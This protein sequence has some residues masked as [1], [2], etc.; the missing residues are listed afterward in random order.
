MV[1]LLVVMLSG[2]DISYSQNWLWAKSAAGDNKDKSYSVATDGSGNV[3]VT[4]DYPSSS[5]TFGAYTL[6]NLGTGNGFLVKY[7]ASGNVLWA[8]NIGGPGDALG[9]G[10][11]IDGSG[12]I[13][14][15]GCF[16]QPTITVGTFTL[17]NTNTFGY[18]DI[19]LAKY[20]PSG[21]VLWA[22]S[23][24]GAT[25]EQA[26]AV[27]VDALG[28]AYITGEFGDFMSTATITFG[29]I[30]LTASNSG[31]H[32][33]FLAKY[34]P[35]GNVLWA[36]NAGGG[37]WDQAT[38]VAADVSGNAYI[39]GYFSS[40]TIPFGAFPLTNAGSGQNVFLVKYYPTGTVL[41]A[42]SAGGIAYDGGS[43][44]AD[45]PAGNVYLTGGFSSPT[46]TFG[47][48][49]LT[50]AGS[51]DVFLTKYDPSGAVLWAQNAG[52]N[53]DDGGGG[54]AV[55]GTASVYLTGGFTS[56][57]ILKR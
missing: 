38:S 11:A 8:Q 47:A 25:G 21:T 15:S 46:I 2:V 28:N 20:D 26:T 30:T 41:W 16:G 17:T 42:Q 39:T 49:T 27:A 32:D 45:D 55:N 53:F 14:V 3:Y 51:A 18:Y 19:F 4:G 48:T 29:T 13:Y 6:T 10:I 23:A 54:V 43:S 9:T 22:K 33:V 40:P 7:D 5:I 44:L 57:S 35:S 31:S 50:S 24:G 37:V 12:N 52:G 1:L 36:T 34:D 56:P